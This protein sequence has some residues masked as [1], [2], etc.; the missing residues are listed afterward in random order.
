MFI[1]FIRSILEQTF[2]VRQS[3][4]NKEDSDNLEGIQKSDVKVILQEDYSDYTDGLHQIRLKPL[5]EQ[6]M[7]LCK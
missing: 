5:Y 4:L 3:S 7:Q 2:V 6:I 1:L